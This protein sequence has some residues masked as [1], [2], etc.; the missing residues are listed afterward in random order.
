MTES[1][2]YKKIFKPYLVKNGCFHYRVEHE[3]MP[4]IY[5]SK[6]GFGVFWFELKVINKERKDGLIKPDWRTGQ[7]AWIREHK[8]LGEDSVVLCLY[9]VGKV[10][11]LEPKEFYTK[12][13]LLDV[14][15][16]EVFNGHEFFV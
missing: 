15:L 16:K 7:L 1:E 12:E 13:E 10:F 14:K 8:R 2:F 4:D 11:Y 6:K 3:R 9:Y 5:T